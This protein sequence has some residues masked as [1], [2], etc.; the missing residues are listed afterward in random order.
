MGTLSG[1]KIV[2]AVD[3]SETAKDALHYALQMA[4]DL[5]CT[6]TAVTAI[7]TR[8]PGYRAAYFSFVDRHILTELRQFAAAVAEEAKR[9][10]AD[11]AAVEL[12]TEILEG[13][14]EIFEQIVDFLAGTQD[15]AF[16]VMGSSGHDVRDRLMIGSTTQRL[17]LEVASRNMKVP[18][19]VVP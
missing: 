12:Q 8:M 13:E 6:V 16:L 15:A 4:P 11:S 10:A 18:V 7:Q 3:G 19:L 5:K 2:V 14:K 1:K 17:I 9:I